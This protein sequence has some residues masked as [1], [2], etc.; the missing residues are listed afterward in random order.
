MILVCLAKGSDFEAFKAELNKAGYV[1]TQGKA[2]TRFFCVETTQ[3]EFTLSDYKD[4][5]LVEED[6]VAE[7]AAVDD[8]YFYTYDGISFQEQNPATYGRS[9]ALARICR[10]K[11]PFPRSGYSPLDTFNTFFRQ[12]RT[13]AGV[14]IYICDVGYAP[15]LATFEDRIA[16][17]SPELTGGYQDTSGSSH[18]VFV[19]ACAAGKDFGVATGANIWFS[20]VGAGAAPSIMFT[21]MDNALSHYLSRAGTNR[22]AVMNC[23][24][25]NNP[26]TLPTE[27]VRIIASDIMDAGMPITAAA[28]NFSFDHDVYDIIPADAVDV[29]NVGGSAI[30]DTPMNWHRYGTSFGTQVTL[31]APGEKIFVPHYENMI[32]GFFLINGTSFAAPFTA[33]VVACM[34]EGYQRPTTRTQVQAI[35]AKLIENSTKDVLDFPESSGIEIRGNNRL[36]YLDPNIAIEPITGLTPL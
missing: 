23:S 20:P 24:F 4:V 31:F 11:N 19:A 5:I 13:G 9:W 12:T 25:G 27:S 22:P 36:L 32:D 6:P 2:L 26:P 17:V 29:I 14:D 30:H 10:R 8:P 16:H 34:L 1:Y 33:G 28:M 21:G 18:G 35:N 7:L 3:K 15:H